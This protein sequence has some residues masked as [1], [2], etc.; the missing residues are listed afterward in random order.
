MTNKEYQQLKFKIGEYAMFDGFLLYK[1]IKTNLLKLLRHKEG[2]NWI[3]L[4][5]HPDDILK[6]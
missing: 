2:N 1:N 4:N 3:L 5:E 6:V